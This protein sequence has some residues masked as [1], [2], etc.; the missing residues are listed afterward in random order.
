MLINIKKIENL[1]INIAPYLAE[2]LIIFYYVSLF[3]FIL[4]LIKL[5]FEY[6]EEFFGGVILLILFI[7]LFYM[8]NIKIS[9]AILSFILF[10]GSILILNYILSD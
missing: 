8:L 7:F 10:F 6:K 2:I 5:S 4:Y 9:L 1:I 3:L